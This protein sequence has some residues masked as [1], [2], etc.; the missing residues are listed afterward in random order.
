[1]VLLTLQIFDFFLESLIF[2]LQTP[3]LLI[4]KCLLLIELLVKRLILDGCVFLERPPL[5]LQFRVFL[6][7]ALLVH[8]VSLLLLHGLA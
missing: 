8:A 4:A 2:L 5:V 7:Q 1:M 3:H 6:L